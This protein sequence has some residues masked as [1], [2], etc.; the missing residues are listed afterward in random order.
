MRRVVRTYLSPPSALPRITPT[1]SESTSQFGHPASS[2]AERPALTDHIWPSSKC[3]ATL[4]GMG[5]FHAIG[6]HGNSR[7][8]PP[9]FEYVLS[10]GL[11]GSAS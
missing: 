2:R 11:Y 1:R 6:S 7:T 3:A 5:S 8:Q 4:G 9:I 10:S